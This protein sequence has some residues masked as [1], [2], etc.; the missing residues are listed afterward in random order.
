MNEGLEASKSMLS[1]L[2]SIGYPT[3]LVVFTGRPK[4]NPRPSLQIPPKKSEV[5]LSSHPGAVT[6]RVREDPG[7]P[8]PHRP[9]ARGPR[10]AARVREV[11]GTAQ[12]HG[13][14]G[15]AGPRGTRG[16][17]SLVAGGGD[18]GDRDGGGEDDDDDDDDEDEDDGPWG[19]E[20]VDE[21]DEDD[22]DEDD[23]DDDDDFWTPIPLGRSPQIPRDNHVYNAI[24]PF[25]YY[26]GGIPHIFLCGCW[27]KQ[28][29]LAPGYPL[30]L[31]P[32]EF[33]VAECL[34]VDNCSM[35]GQSIGVRRERINQNQ[36]G[37]SRAPQMPDCDSYAQAHMDRS[38]VSS[39]SVRNNKVNYLDNPLESVPGVP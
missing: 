6:R 10:P 21:D 34:V 16:N 38:T 26:R 5:L 4:V 2:R 9:A 13:A 37:G 11:Q 18:D 29:L 15:G 3:F 35:C 8:F 39:Q 7:V 12:G 30:R 17:D 32:S 20:D 23:D 24:I 14:H 36:R 33:L 28:G 22:G 25:A 1:L 31:T 19:L 27:L